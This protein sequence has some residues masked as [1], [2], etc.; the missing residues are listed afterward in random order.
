MSEFE[1]LQTHFSS[2]T[3]QKWIKEVAVFAHTD[4]GEGRACLP[5]RCGPLSAERKI[6]MLLHDAMVLDQKSS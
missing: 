6:T 1:H 2:F 5:V 3:V 4:P